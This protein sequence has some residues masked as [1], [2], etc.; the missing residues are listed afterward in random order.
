MAVPIGRCALLLEKHDSRPAQRTS[1]YKQRGN[2]LKD[3]HPLKVLEKGR[4]VE[5]L[6]ESLRHEL[7]TLGSTPLTPCPPPGKRKAIFGTTKL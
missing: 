3:Q 2:D 4:I 5:Y 1:G 7:P 6:P